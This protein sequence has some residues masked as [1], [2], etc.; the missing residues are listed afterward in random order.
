M[1]VISSSLIKKKRPADEA[2]DATA[3]F[4]GDQAEKKF[5]TN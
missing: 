5:K 3:S 1:N 2:I 4:S